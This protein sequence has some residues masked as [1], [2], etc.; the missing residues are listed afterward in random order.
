MNSQQE[1][2]KSL[3]QT[4]KEN[5]SEMGKEDVQ[6]TAGEINSKM[7]EEAELEEVVVPS[8]VNYGPFCRANST[9]SE[10]N[11]YVI[12]DR[13]VLESVQNY[14]SVMTSLQRESRGANSLERGAKWGTY[15]KLRSLS[16]NSEFGCIRNVN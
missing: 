9:E 12:R 16:S 3:T 10:K 11:F 6:E 2:A 1:M 7:V 5:K 13:N 14:R 4:A 8:S 15:K